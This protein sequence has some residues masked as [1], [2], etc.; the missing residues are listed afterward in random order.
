MFESVAAE[1]RW[2]ATEPGF[3]REAKAARFRE[4]IT[5][6]GRHFVACEN[7]TVVGTLSIF[8]GASGKFGL[9]MMVRADRRGQGIGSVLVREAIEWARSEGIPSIGLE[10]FPHNVAAI[11]LYERMGFVRTG[12][13]F[14]IER[15]SGEIW[16]ALEM[17]LDLS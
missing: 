12:R 13:E 6:A 4:T 2:I 8:R 14:P 9:G 16:N 11:R 17:R 7:D 1:R 3:D 15:Q 10:V 5:G